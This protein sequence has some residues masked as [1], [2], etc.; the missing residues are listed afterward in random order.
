MRISVE[1]V[2]DA[3][4]IWQAVLVPLHDKRTPQGSKFALTSLWIHPHLVR[5]QSSDGRELMQ[6]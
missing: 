2:L 4:P 6:I 1:G 5:Q 3:Y